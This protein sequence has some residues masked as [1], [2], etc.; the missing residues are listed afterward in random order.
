MLLHDDQMTSDTE[1]KHN[2]AAAV[3]VIVLCALCVLFAALEWL[4]AK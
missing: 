2:K 4:D 3:C 1:L